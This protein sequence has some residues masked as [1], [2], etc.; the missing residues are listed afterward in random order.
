MLFVVIGLFVISFCSAYAEHEQYTPFNLTIS[1]NNATDCNLSYIQYNN[2]NSTIFNT[3]L[4]QN[5]RTFHTVIEGSNFTDGNVCVHVVCTDG[6]IFEEG[7]QCRTVTLAGKVVNDTTIIADII[8][9]V[10][11]LLLI[12]GF[13]IVTKDINFDQWHNSI[14]HKYENRNYIKLVLSSLMF[15]VI[16]NKFIIYYLIGLPI[17]LLLMDMVYTFNLGGMIA[18]MQAVF[19]I[20]LV[21]ILI[22][23][24]IFMS[25]V[26]EWLMDLLKQ[27]KDLEWGV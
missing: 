7:S 1:S 22:V 19:Y 23:G 6:V 24:L 4:T 14:I 2:G 9:L 21:G 18:I 17:L 25:H 27:V 15:N 16:K 12:I 11:F 10:F 20:Y 5:F 3:P 13:F 8:L 26:Q